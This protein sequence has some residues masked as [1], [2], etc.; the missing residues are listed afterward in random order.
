M[1]VGIHGESAQPAERAAFRN[2]G[3]GM[4]DECAH[5]IAPQDEAKTPFWFRRIVRL[6]LLGHGLDDDKNTI[7]VLFVCKPDGTDAALWLLGLHG[8][9]GISLRRRLGDRVAAVDYDE[10][11]P[12]FLRQCFDLLFLCQKG[13]RA[14]SGARLQIEGAPAGMAYIVRCEYLGRDF[15]LAHFLD[16]RRLTATILGPSSPTLTTVVDAGPTIILWK[17]SR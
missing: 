7:V 4:Q 1:P 14:G 11:L 3:L 13:N 6:G 5:L 10:K 9:S 15:D 17:R 8:K 16:A 12:Q 2:H